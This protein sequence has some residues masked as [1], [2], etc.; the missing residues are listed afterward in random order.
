M[1]DEPVLR[2]SY[3]PSVDAG[4]LHLQPAD[5]IQPSVVRTEHVGASLHLDFDDKDR[6]VGIEF[7]SASVLHPALLAEA[8]FAP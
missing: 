3:D 5:T 8:G 6:L 1:P 7:L 2:L 4:Y